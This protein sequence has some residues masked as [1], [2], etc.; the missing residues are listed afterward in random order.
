M[1]FKIKFVLPA[2]LPNVRAIQ[3]TIQFGS[4]HSSTQNDLITAELL[5]HNNT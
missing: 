5:A 4:L 3:Y 2:K 1:Y